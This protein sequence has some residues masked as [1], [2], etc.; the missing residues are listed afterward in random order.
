MLSPLSHLYLNLKVVNSACG[1]EI[2]QLW[3]DGRPQVQMD[4]RPPLKELEKRGWT[5][6]W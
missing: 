4:S 5:K 6:G 1:P 3:M 2:K